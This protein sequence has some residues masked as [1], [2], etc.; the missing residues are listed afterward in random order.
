MP[1]TGRRRGPGP[2]RTAGGGSVGPG[3][4]P[5]LR[6]CRRAGAFHGTLGPVPVAGGPGGGMGRGAARRGGGGLPG[7]GAARRGHLF[8]AAGLRLRAGVQ[9]ARPANPP[10][11]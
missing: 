4:R 8:A 5:C 1:V 11:R 6:P 9:A 2:L 3:L 10:G 7:A